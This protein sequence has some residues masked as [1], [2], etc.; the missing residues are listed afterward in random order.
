MTCAS[1]HAAVAGFAS[2]T[3][4]MIAQNPKSMHPFTFC[5]RTL[6][7]VPLIF[8]SPIS[9]EVSHPVLTAVAALDLLWSTYSVKFR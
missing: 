2:S 6:L 5:R 1:G 8:I 9:L 3:A 4:A 7:E